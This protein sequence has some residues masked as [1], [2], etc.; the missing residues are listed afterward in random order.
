MHPIWE[1][2][3]NISTNNVQ[4]FGIHCL[5]GYVLHPLLSGCRLCMDTRQIQ[6]LQALV[7][8]AE[9]SYEMLNLLMHFKLLTYLQGSIIL[10]MSFIVHMLVL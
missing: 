5:V 6:I 7:R 10:I 9:M 4:H 2:S 8:L 1:D 3:G